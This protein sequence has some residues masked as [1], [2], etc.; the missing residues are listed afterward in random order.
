MSRTSFDAA[1]ERALA[2]AMA[3]DP[4]VIV[5]GEDVRTLRLNLLARFGERRV[6]NAPISESAFLGAAV[7][8]AMAGL[9][10]VVEVMLV[11]FLPVAM[12]ALVNEAAKVEAFSG[13]RWTVPM[14]VR[15]PC[16]GGY[17]DAGQHEQSLWGMLA[18]IPGL[19]VVVPSNP[20]DAA[21]LMLAALQHDGPVLYLEHKLL[22]ASWLDFMGR[23]GRRTV[24]FEVP[25]EGAA[26]PVPRRIRPAPLG[27]AA[28]RRQGGD[29]S[30]VS[31]GVGVHRALEAA[32]VLAAEGTECSV[33]DLRSVSPLD[34]ETLRSEAERS[35]RI[36]V[37]DEDYREFGL[38]G[39]V[40]A[41]LLEAGLRLGYG[42]V[43][44]EETI[45]YA[46]HLEDQVLPGTGRILAAARQLLQ[47][48]PG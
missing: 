10:P 8:A 18:H 27:R 3:D 33:V 24:A 14:V 12:S 22:S 23:G 32:A 2:Q 42:R 13:G 39:E 46:R 40:A 37:I 35:G 45:P 7:G 19:S 4:R 41:S 28:V 44:T 16:G 6:R 21:A 31:L 15:A 29:L 1:V 9:R 25:R 30:L 34:R 48:A 38:S 36:L 20:A 26:G 11:D 17:G 47:R 5:L 43:C